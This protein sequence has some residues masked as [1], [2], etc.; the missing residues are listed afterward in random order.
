[1][2]FSNENPFDFLCCQ[3]VNLPPCPP[4][5]KPPRLCQTMSC[6]EN[7]FQFNS[8][9]TRRI[10]GGKCYK[11]TNTHT[12]THSYVGANTFTVYIH[13]SI[14]SIKLQHHRFIQSLLFFILSYLAV[15][16]CTYVS[17][18]SWQ[19][20][21]SVRAGWII[22]SGC[23]FFVL[24]NGLSMALMVNITM[25]TIVCYQ[26]IAQPTMLVSGL[27]M[28]ACVCVCGSLF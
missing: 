10:F 20:L 11:N 1:M 18:C 8:V 14:H 23:V 16:L 3:P 15:K 27:S 22:M 28:R 13:P 7:S 12:C 5:L 17:H 9:C 2:V 25:A 19:C 4:K 6:L 24:N 26:S 21:D